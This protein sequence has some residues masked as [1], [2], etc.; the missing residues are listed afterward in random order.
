MSLNIIES[1]ITDI[2]EMLFMAYIHGGDSGGPYGVNE[3][4]MLISVN[5]FLSHTGLDNKY[6]LGTLNRKY[7]NCLYFNVPQIVERFVVEN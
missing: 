6:E 3:D 7:S 1:C 5:N 2:N 4:G